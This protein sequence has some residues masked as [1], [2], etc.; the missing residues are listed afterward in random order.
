MNRWSGYTSIAFTNTTLQF[1]VSGNI[2]ERGNYRWNTE[3]CNER[4]VSRVALPQK[5]LC[6]RR[7]RFLRTRQGMQTRTTKAHAENIRRPVL[8]SQVP[9]ASRMRAAGTTCLKDASRTCNLD[10]WSSRSIAVHVT[11]ILQPHTNMCRRKFDLH[12]EPILFSFSPSISSFCAGPGRLASTCRRG[13]RRS[14]AWKKNAPANKGLGKTRRAEWWV[15][16]GEE[17]RGWPECNGKRA[18]AAF[19][20]KGR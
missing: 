18:A 1:S 16:G 5:R 10:V 14:K 4:I 15:G 19:R 20:W 8:K 12:G 6:Q 2:V 9:L 13:W 17:G 11:R 3:N 7:A